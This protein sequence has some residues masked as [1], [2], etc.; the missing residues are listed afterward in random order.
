MKKIVLAALASGLLLSGCATTGSVTVQPTKIP[1]AEAPT[2]APLNMR[3]VQWK[4]LT[5]A[6]L[7]ALLIELEQNPDPNFALYTLDN[8]NFQAL[9]LN[10]VDIRRFILEQQQVVVYYRDL[11]AQT[12]P[13]E[14]KKEEPKKKRF[15]LF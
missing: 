7:E 6:D 9:N 4:I 5:K 8:G 1:A 10:L 13:A 2:P 15:G 3:D 12:H 11:E 14:E